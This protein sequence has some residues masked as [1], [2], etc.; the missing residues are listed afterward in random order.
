[1]HGFN[2]ERSGGLSADSTEVVKTCGISESK[3]L[4]FAM[5]I[6]LT[7]MVV[8]RQPLESFPKPITT[9]QVVAANP[10]D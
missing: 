1:M 5:P 9:E 4:L 2:G 6:I 3:C 7:A 10:V 8:C